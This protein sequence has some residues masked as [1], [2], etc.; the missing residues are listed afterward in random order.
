MILTG[1]INIIIFV[2]PF[3]NS[4]IVR[5]LIQSLNM[6]DTILNLNPLH[7]AVMYRQDMSHEQPDVDLVIL[8]K[9][10]VK[11]KSLSE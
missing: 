10:T 4:K 8:R 6:T 11:C 9:F 1:Q 7:I 5:A 3:S 2:R